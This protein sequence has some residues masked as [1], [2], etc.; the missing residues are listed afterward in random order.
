MTRVLGA[1]EINT[2]VTT[3]VKGILG[4]EVSLQTGLQQLNAQLNEIIKR[5]DP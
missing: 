2:A 4:N 5:T 3:T 1:G